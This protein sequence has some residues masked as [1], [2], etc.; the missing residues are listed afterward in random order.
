MKTQLLRGPGIT[1]EL[2]ETEI[3]PDNP[4][5]GTPAMVYVGENSATYWCA[6]GTGEV[7]MYTLSERQM[8][9]L[10]AQNDIVAEFLDQHS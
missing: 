3:F 8:R 10:D 1:L 6:L 2:D 4:G 5:N 7:D 9:W